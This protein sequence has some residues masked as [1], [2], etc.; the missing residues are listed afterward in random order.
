MYI[1]PINSNFSKWSKRRGP[2]NDNYD[3]TGGATPIAIREPSFYGE[4]LEE[5]PH[6]PWSIPG[7][8]GA[9]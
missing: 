7:V 6:R 2:S 1:S 5:T 9:F 4:G 3:N 8:G